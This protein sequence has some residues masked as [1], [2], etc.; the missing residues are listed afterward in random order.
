[1]SDVEQVRQKWTADRPQYEAF[2]K[3][4][5]ERLRESIKPLGVW[6]EVEARAK[7]IDSLVK[8]LLTKQ[9][10]TF[11]SVPD[12]VGVRVIIRYR[13]D[14]DGVIARVRNLF[15]SDEPE[16]K[17]RLLGTDRVGYLSVH[18]D[19]TRLRQNDA[20]AAQFPPN[21]FWAELQVRTL[22]QHLWSEMSHDTMYKSQDMI[23]Q[24]DPDIRRRVS[25][26]AGQLEVADREFDRLNMDLSSQITVRL[27][28]VLERHYYAVATQ[29][30][31]LE[32]SVEVLDALA[33]LVPDQN[34]GSFATSLNEF[35]NEKQS[36]IDRVYEKARE[37]G[38][39]DPETPAFLFQPEV[40]L[41]YN[42]LSTSPD[43]MRMVW[44]KI[45]PERELERIANAFGMSLD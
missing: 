19:N 21:I 27:L 45:Y 34:F 1:V 5:A 7:T 2:G 37:L 26:M 39:E 8:K 22:A 18:L 31:N 41:I 30:P 10:H 25:L 28:Q 38:S 15:D 29:R 16:D 4:L 6:F 44:N 23:S 42:L 36:V 9:N 11:E 13:S 43:K 20:R 3:V 14:V 12:K 32:L 33:S 17:E 24:L 35:L 40:L